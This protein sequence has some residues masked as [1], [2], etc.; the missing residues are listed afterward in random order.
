MELKTQEDIDLF[1]AEIE[2]DP[3]F[4]RILIE[5]IKESLQ[6]K[7]RELAKDIVNKEHIKI[8]K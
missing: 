3:T 6:D 1:L 4:S 7:Y 8:I 2:N 5:R